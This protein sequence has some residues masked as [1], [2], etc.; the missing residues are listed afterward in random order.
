MT[1]A[2]L[3]HVISQETGIILKDTK[4]IV[5]SFLESVSKSLVEGNHI[6]LRGFGTFKNKVRKPRIARNP[7]TQE[8]LN[9]GERVVP[10]F[11]FSKDVVELVKNNN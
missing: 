5:D 2:D 7:N 4:I 1:K 9:L 3:V 6:E 10:T 11:K 8:V